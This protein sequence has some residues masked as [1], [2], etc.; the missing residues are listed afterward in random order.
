MKRKK[1]KKNFN[2]NQQSFYFEDYFKTNQKF[3]REK[4]FLIIED[5][6]YLLFFCFFSLIL[7]FSLKI[8]FISLQNLNYGETTID[9]SFNKLRN[10][11][12][13]RNGIIL[14][15]NIT[16]FHAAIKPDLIK[17][18]KKFLVKIKL[19]MP[20]IDKERLINNLNQ[21]KYFYLKKRLTDT[22][23]EK[24]WKLGEK[25]IIF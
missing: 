21:K 25:G 20:E 10:D 17:D 7:I 12:V 24:L 1:I 9:K 15:R 2:K 3:K 11:I 4:N 8:I 14:S 18:K 16:A 13:D 5:R 6:L 23:R 22:E 19:A